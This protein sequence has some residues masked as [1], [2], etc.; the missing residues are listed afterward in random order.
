MKIKKFYQYSE[1]VNE[2]HDTPENY[3]SV[4]LNKLKRKIDKM[5]EY[6]DGKGGKVLTADELERVDPK[7]ITFKDLG[8]ILDSSEVSK[9]S[10][11]YDS[12]TIKFRDAENAYTMIIMI[13]IKDAIP[14]EDDINFSSDDIEMAYIKFKKYDESGIEMIGQIDKNVKIKNIDESFLIDLKIELDDEYDEN[15]DFEIET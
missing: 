13:D 12:F 4:A 14:E 6:S 1:K 9:Y 10:K 15:E 11:L 2:M 7:N 5:F 3:V 8:M